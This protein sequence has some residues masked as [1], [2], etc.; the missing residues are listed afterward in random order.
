M[1]TNKDFKMSK[2]HKIMLALM[3]DSEK[4]PERKKMFIESQVAYTKAKQAKFKENNKGE[5]A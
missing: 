3:T 1:K 4:R 5:E 2:S